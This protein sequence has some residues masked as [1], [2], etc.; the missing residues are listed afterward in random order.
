MLVV[1]VTVGHYPFLL[2]IWGS[3]ESSLGPVVLC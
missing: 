3:V 1:I 2:L